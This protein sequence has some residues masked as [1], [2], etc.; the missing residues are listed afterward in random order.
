M[1]SPCFTDKQTEHQSQKQVLTTTLCGLGGQANICLVEG[2]SRYYF[3]A[4]GESHNCSLVV[5]TSP[6]PLVTVPLP[7]LPPGNKNFISSMSTIALFSLS[8]NQVPKQALC[9]TVLHT[10]QCACRWPEAFIEMHILI[11]VG[12]GATQNSAF[13]TAAV[14][15]LRI[16]VLTPPYGQQGTTEPPVTSV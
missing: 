9:A 13:L 16:L 1:S 8:E 6:P 10:S 3:R 4:C 14:G 7:H 15:V 12:C 2:E 11:Y 5:C